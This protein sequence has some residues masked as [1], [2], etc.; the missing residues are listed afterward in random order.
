VDKL[1][2]DPFNLHL[3]GGAFVMI[4]MLFLIGV[5]LLSQGIIG[6]YLSH[7]HSETQNRPLYVI[8]QLNSKGLKDVA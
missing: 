2:G 3:T 4:L 6:L 8:D 7:I 1:F 5:L